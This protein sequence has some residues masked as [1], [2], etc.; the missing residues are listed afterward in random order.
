MFGDVPVAVVVVV[1]LGSLI[2]SADGNVTAAILVFSNNETSLVCH[3]SSFPFTKNS[4]VLTNLKTAMET[5]CKVDDDLHHG[6][7]L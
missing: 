5:F 4:T 6:K 2:R 3:L 7:D 1:C